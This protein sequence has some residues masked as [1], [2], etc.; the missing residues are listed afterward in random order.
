MDEIYRAETSLE[1]FQKMLHPS[2]EEVMGHIMLDTLADIYRAADAMSETTEQ[3]KALMPG[4]T[5]I[6]A[7]HR[8]FTYSCHHGAG[9]VPAPDK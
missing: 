8:P 4:V 2:D 5:L 1:I 6:T 9:R 3:R 7:E